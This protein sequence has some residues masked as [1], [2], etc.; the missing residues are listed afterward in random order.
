MIVTAQ[1]LY[2]RAIDLRRTSAARVV[3]FSYRNE[4]H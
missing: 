2:E 4:S 3:S 1:F